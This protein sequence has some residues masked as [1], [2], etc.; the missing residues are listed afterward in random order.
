MKKTINHNAFTLIELLVVIAIIAIL[1][2]LLLPALDKAR[3]AA[4]GV[5]CVSNLRQLGTA[6][7][8]YRND[9]EDYL[10][11]RYDDTIAYP[12]RTWHGRLVNQEYLPLSNVFFCPGASPSSLE[13]SEVVDKNSSVLDFSA[14]STEIYG[15]VL[16]TPP[17]ETNIYR[18]YKAQNISRPSEFFLIA[19]SWIDYSGFPNRNTPGP[20]YTISQTS[21]PWGVDLRH[22]QNANAMFL[23]GHVEA[24]SSSDLTDLDDTQKETMD[25]ASSEEYAVFKNGVKINP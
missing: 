25:W 8:M 6:V 15:M 4:Q 12:D 7:Q 24:L 22:N 10:P 18:P 9:Y 20:G 23:D 11:V 17:G 19:D 14:T 2:S 5:A 3:S 1:A 13:G 21:S 16:W